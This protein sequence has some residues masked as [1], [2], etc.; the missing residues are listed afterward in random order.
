MGQAMVAV[1]CPWFLFKQGFEALAVQDSDL[2]SV[3]LDDPL[4]LHFP[5]DPGQGG[6]G[7]PEKLTEFLLA[8]GQ[9]NLIAA[10]FGQHQYIL[11]H[12]LFDGFKR[13][14]P[15]PLGKEMSAVTDSI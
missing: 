14:K 1:V 7:H 12:L 5:H 4:F 9:S 6:P 15:Q 13:H 3:A 8:F 2:L 10:V 11:R